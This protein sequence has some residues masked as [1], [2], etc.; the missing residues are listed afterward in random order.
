MAR[1]T[2]VVTLGLA[3]LL[4]NSARAGAQPQNPVDMVGQWT[5]NIN[6]PY[7]VSL[8]DGV[9]TW[10]TPMGEGG[11]IVSA[12]GG[13]QTTWTDAL[14]VH[15]ASGTVVA[16]D[17]AGRPIRVQWS[18]GLVIERTAAQAAG[19]PVPG[20]PPVGTPA[21]VAEQAAQQ[22]TQQAMGLLGVLVAKL[23][24]P[25]PHPPAGSPAA[26]VPPTVPPPAPFGT[27]APPVVTP[28]PPAGTT[29]PPAPP[30]APYYGTPSATTGP[31]AM[32]SGSAGPVGSMTVGAPDA[33]AGVPL[34]PG[35]AYLERIIGGRAA[36]GVVQVGVVPP[37]GTPFLMPK[38]IPAQAALFYAHVIGD[39]LG[40][41]DVLDLSQ[42]TLLVKM[43][44]PG[45]PPGSPEEL[46]SSSLAAAFGRAADMRAFEG[47]TALAIWYGQWAEWFARL[48]VD[49]GDPSATA[50]TASHGRAWAMSQPPDVLKKR[51]SGFASTVMQK[52]SVTPISF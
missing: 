12:P 23:S 28:A 3:L 13:L 34:R 15:T 51:V 1:F 5:S 27:P 18:N 40:Q 10:S 14:G 30:P 46:L 33:L 31:A 37:G 24:Q 49:L 41:D 25:Q 11:T 4:G 52:L 2:G 32:P 47:P 48:G 26:A 29:Y 50:T 20:A 21:S 17:A 36:S 44:E 45:M 6:V 16:R 19:A 22:A 7:T 35:P 9:V 8:K 42:K 38:P 39:L 43:R